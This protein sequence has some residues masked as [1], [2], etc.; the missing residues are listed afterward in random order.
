MSKLTKFYH[1]ALEYCEENV[2]GEDYIMVT[3]KMIICPSCG[4][5]GH[6]V[7][8]DIDDSALVDSMREDGDDEGL[9]AYFSGSFDVLCEECKGANVIF[10][11]DPEAGPLWAREAIDSWE[12]EEREQNRISKAEIRMGA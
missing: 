3:G 5:N 6:H 12:K 2:T 7:R 4:G 9:E 1:P 11:P 10:A 8:R